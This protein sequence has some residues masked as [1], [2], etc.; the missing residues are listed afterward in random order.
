MTSVRIAGTAGFLLCIALAY[1][2]G[3]RIESLRADAQLA[4][5]QKRAAEERDV[6]NQAQLQRERNQAAA[7]DQVAAHY[8]EERQHAKTEADRVIAD[9]RAGTLR[10]RDRWATQMLAGKALAATRAARTDAGTADRAQ[11]AGRIVRAAVEC[12]AQVRGLQSIL[13]KERE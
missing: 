10:L 8:E 13:T 3:H 1:T 5:F 7:F 2:A 11:S 6:A 12:D 9:L 4:A